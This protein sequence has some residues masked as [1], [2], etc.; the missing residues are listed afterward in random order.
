MARGERIEH[1]L[2]ADHEHAGRER[3]GREP[4]E[5]RRQRERDKRRDDARV[6]RA[7]DA[8]RAEPVAQHPDAERA[9]PAADV[10]A[11]LH[12]ADRRAAEPARGHQR[13]Q[14][15]QQEIQDDQR[16]EVA[17]PKRKR[18]A[19]AAAAEERRA[20]GGPRAA[21]ARGVEVRARLRQAAREQRHE[22]QRPEPADVED[23]PPLRVA[24]EQHADCRCDHAAERDSAIH[25]A[26]R[27]AAQPRLHR[28]RRQRDQVRHRAAEPDTR[29]HAHDDEHRETRRLRGG[30]RQ[31]AERAHRY[32][33][34]A[35]APDPV[36]EPAAKQR[37]RQQAER[38]CAERP[39]HL[40]DRQAEL[41]RHAR[42]RD[43]DRL[44]IEPFEQRDREAQRERRRDAALFRHGDV[45]FVS[46]PAAFAPARAGC[47][48]I[49]VDVVLL[50]L[51]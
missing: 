5:T 46:R 21:H 6:H 1:R 37:P 36:G 9:E 19:G 8:R 29:E 32:D 47:D 49:V 24:H 41:A 18:C 23:V 20:R 40:R 34:H 39:P 2:P 43:A 11:D 31:Q 33:Q 45:H 27:A 13:R 44:Q 28:L 48:A 17:D 38:A 30:D 12:G 35:L 42:R 16:A 14:P 22:Q 4:R 25:R 10:E 7:D 51:P 26:D 15:V 50:R 3:G